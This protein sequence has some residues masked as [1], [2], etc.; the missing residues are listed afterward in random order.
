MLVNDYLRLQFVH[1]NVYEKLLQ[2]LLSAYAQVPI[3]SP[4]EEGIL[5]GPVHRPA[6]IDLFNKTIQTAKE[7]GGKVLFGGEAGRIEGGNFCVPTIIEI[8]SKQAVCHD[9][10]FVPILYVHKFQVNQSKAG[11]S[12]DLPFLI[13]S[14]LGT[15]HCGEQFSQTRSVQ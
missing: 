4:F 9:E 5:C 15:S 2:S 14:V 3:G 13:L 12:A 10:A 7:Q 11:A 8:D 1:E 6:S